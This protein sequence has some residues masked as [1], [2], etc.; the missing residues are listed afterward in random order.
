MYV[1]KTMCTGELK[2]SEIRRGETR[3]GAGGEERGRWEAHTK[4]A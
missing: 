3:L 1:L 4:G 2:Q